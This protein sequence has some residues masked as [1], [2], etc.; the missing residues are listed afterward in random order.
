MHG[1]KTQTNRVRRWVL[2]LALSSG[3]ALQ[4]FSLAAA[5]GVTVKTNYYAVSG[6]TV[7]ELWQSLQQQRPWKSKFSFA[8]RTDWTM[9]WSYQFGEEGDRVRVSRFELRTDIVM[10]L[11]RWIPPKNA[12]EEVVRRWAR[13]LRALMLHEAG[14][15]TIAQQATADIRRQVSALPAYGSR[16]ELREGLVATVHE[17][18]DRFRQQDRDY[19]QRTRHGATQG[20]LLMHGRP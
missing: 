5:D 19:D 4:T 1:Q 7:R 20:A 16:A 13:Y 6:A 8:A 15:V 18:Q 9:R 2:W 3:V 10:V 14:H 17:L 11:P 12:D